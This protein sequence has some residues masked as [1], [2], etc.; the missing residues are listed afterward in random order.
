VVIN[1]PP[2]EIKKEFYDPLGLRLLTSTA[3]YAPFGR[4]FLASTAGDYVFDS[5]TMTGSSLFRS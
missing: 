3:D 2:E 1:W 5:A 4:V